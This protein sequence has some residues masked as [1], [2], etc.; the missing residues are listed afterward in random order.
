MKSSITFNEERKELTFF[1]NGKAVQGIIGNL[2]VVVYNRIKA[3]IE[4][5]TNLAVKAIK[6]SQLKVL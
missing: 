3:T 5:E 6:Q 4:S 2:A 1:E